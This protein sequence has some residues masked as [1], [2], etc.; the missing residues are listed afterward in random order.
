MNQV[1]GKRY[2][3]H[4]GT[5]VWSAHAMKGIKKGDILAMRQSVLPALT[6]PMTCD[7]NL[8]KKKNESSFEASRMVGKLQVK[9][10][11]RFR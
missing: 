8:N 7:Q 4:V 11:H 6:R 9:R 5:E 1:N 10:V 2:T 3:T